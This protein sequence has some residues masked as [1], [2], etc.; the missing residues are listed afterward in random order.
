MTAGLQDF[1]L[2]PGGELVRKGLDDLAAGR[3][4]EHAFLVLV[5]RSRLTQLGIPIPNMAVAT[6]GLISHVLYDYLAARY[7]DDAYGRYNSL[8][9]RL[10]SFIHALEQ[11]VADRGKRN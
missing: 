7:G 6:P 2:L 5:A 3:Q 1:D 4:S 9:R 11:S 10:R 8:L